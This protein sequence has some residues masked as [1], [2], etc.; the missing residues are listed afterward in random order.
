MKA[1]GDRTKRTG[2]SIQERSVAYFRRR[3]SGSWEII[4]RRQSLPRPIYASADSELEARAWAREMEAKLDAGILPVD[5][6][7][8]L[9]RTPM[10]VS[11]WV[12]EYERS[13][14]PSESDRPLLPLVV[15]GVGSVPLDGLRP[16]HILEWVDRMKAARLT[17]GSIRKRV[18]AL[19]RAL[20][21]AVHRELVAVNVARRLPR[22]FSS[23]GPADGEPV[24]D[25]ARDRRLEPG[26]EARLLEV[27]GD[28]P[29]WRRLFV[30]ALE[31][32]MRLSELY[33]LDAS[34]VDRVR[35][36][37]FLERTKNG[38]KRQV[39]LSSVALTA[40]EDAPRTG[41]VFPFFDG[42]RR[43]TTL[44]LGYHWRRIADQAGCP[45]LHFHDLRHEATCRFFER[46]TLSDTQISLITGHRDPRMLRRYAN[47]RGS[48][49]ADR[50]W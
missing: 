24:T 39:P 3:K 27:I 20:D 4:I 21:V 38:D 23:Y 42:D 19:A 18:G 5:L 34:Q 50:L 8:V 46:T 16:R 36:T 28:D 35:R 25:T 22:N 9:T 12:G 11:R 33:T 44:R 30:L 2:L 26:E 47:L 41:L 48:D 14:H 10:S 31:T 15:R 45:D 43:R 13:S 49:L 37:I 7:P 17:P 29:D 32:A 1:V 6:A 40:L